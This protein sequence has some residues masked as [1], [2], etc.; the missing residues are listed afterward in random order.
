[1]VDVYMNDELGLDDF[2]FRTATEFMDAPA[3][4]A[5]DLV[6]QPSTSTDTTN[7]LARFN[8]TLGIDET[9]ILVA[10]GIVS[11]SGYNPGTPFDIYVYAMGQE[12]ATTAGNTD[13]LVFHGATD[14]PAVDVVET[15]AG[16]GTIVDAMAYGEF[17]SDGYLNLATA[18][19][20]LDIQA[21]ADNSS[22]AQ[23]DAPLAT[24][25]LD[26]AAIVVVA[27]GFLTPANNSD[28]PAF[29]LWV[30]TAA[31]GAL[32]ELPV[33]TSTGNILADEGSFNVYPN[34]VINNFSM[35]FE[36][37]E[38]AEV[39]IEI[40]NLLGKKIKSTYFGMKTD[41]TH[42]IRY[43]ISDVDN[44]LYF[45]VIKAGKDQVSKKIQVVR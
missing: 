44:G 13:V 7:A 27:S 37:R 32:V 31:G 20:V 33:A 22:V 10:N 42:S 17:N 15:G 24:L 3:A 45:V 4:E 41:G 26:D 43:D 19:Y 9:Y 39:S 28:G 29:G 12:A 35:D 25:S 1:M 8:Y 11:T 40:Y 30:A 16:A 23:Y 38:S 14:A 21:D 34:P 5:F 2:A 18:D 36:L 6:I